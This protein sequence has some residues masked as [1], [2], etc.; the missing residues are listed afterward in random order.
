MKFLKMDIETLFQNN[1]LLLSGGWSAEREIS[2]R[3]GFAVAEA[4]NS[5]KLNFTHLDLKQ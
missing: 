1:I 4:L 3:S 5:H 2:L